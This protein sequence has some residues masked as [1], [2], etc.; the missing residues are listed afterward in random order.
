MQSLRVPVPSWLDDA[1]HGLARWG[2]RAAGVLTLALLLIPLVLSVFVAFTPEETIGLPQLNNITL[3]W[4]QA[5]FADAL[6]REG[7]WN[8]F[9]IGVMAMGIALVTGT[10]A[11]LGLERH[12]IPGA[13]AITLLLL[14]PL[15]VPTVV[16]GMQSLA[17]H[18]RIG[19][20][21]QP[22]SIALAH[23]LIAMP[24]VVLIMRNSIRSVDQQLEQAA[25]GLGASSAQVFFKITLPLVGPSLFAAA[26]FAFII[27]INEFVMTQFLATPRTQTLSTLI[28]P[29]LRY[30]LT[31]LV[32][33]ASAV[34]LGVT[35]AVLL[36]ASRLINMRKLL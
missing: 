9:I 12:R 17:W 24:L 14:A 28:W 1:G 22:I 19:L 21:G 27:S 31:P 32:A 15:F 3:R 26:F 20:W 11:A 8:S 13:N 16:L 29:Q 18:Q 36:M 4:F 34:L 35:L 33:A 2:V 6:W 23:A 7:A 10:A 5:F 25:Q 30:N